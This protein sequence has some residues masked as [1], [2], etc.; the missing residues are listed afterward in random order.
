MLGAVLASPAPSSNFQFS[1]SLS[2]SMKELMAK[3]APAKTAPANNKGQSMCFDNP[4][5]ADRLAW[6]FG[7]QLPEGNAC[8]SL[9]MYGACQ[10]SF[11]TL[12]DVICPASCGVYDDDSTIA[13]L[14]QSVAPNSGID[15]CDMLP[16]FMGTDAMGVCF[17]DQYGKYI[18]NYCPCMCQRSILDYIGISAEQQ[19]CVPWTAFLDSFDYPD[20]SYPTAPN[21]MDTHSAMV[22]GSR[23]CGVDHNSAIVRASCDLPNGL[24]FQ[25]NFGAFGAEGFEVYIAM[26]SEDGRIALF[27]CDGGY[28]GG[29]FCLPRI[30][31]ATI[32]ADGNLMPIESYENEPVAINTDTPYR[33]NIAGNGSGVSWSMGTLD[34]ATG[35]VGEML[36]EMSNSI[37]LDGFKY[38]GVIIGRGGVSASC[39]DDF[40]MEPL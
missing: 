4:G 6:L 39:I 38:A 29:G 10:G 23:L 5:V 27:G 36:V 21:W 8:Q 25:F 31:T 7:A 19:Q 30:L 13:S 14:A 33:F 18:R 26:F 28:N 35:G 2:K 17:H 15:S 3:T 24:A 40:V 11:K 9:A 20:G 12:A 16:G 37:V 32:T 34:M 22:Q 1:D